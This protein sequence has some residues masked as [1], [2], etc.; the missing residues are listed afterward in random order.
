M[1]SGA[2]DD[3]PAIVLARIESRYRL[4]GFAAEFRSDFDAFLA[5][6][7][8]DAATAGVQPYRDPSGRAILSLAD[9]HWF[10]PS[11]T[12]PRELPNHPYIQFW[13][14]L[15]DALTQRAIPGLG[16]ELLG[17]DA[18]AGLFASGML[19]ENPGIRMRLLN[20]TAISVRR[21]AV[22]QVGTPRPAGGPGDI[23]AIEGP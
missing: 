16:P 15:D 19:A 13:H 18:W 8:A 2:R 5:A 3:F 12:W 6:A 14:R 4:P 7:D 11:E 21:Q 22:D 17:D 23:G 9:T 20:R 1:A 10:G